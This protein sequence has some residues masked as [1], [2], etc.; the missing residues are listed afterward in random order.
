[1]KTKI[2]NQAEYKRK[3]RHLH[4]R[5][6]IVG[7]PDFPRVCIF[8]SS[9]H[10]YAQIIDD[11]KGH[12]LAA[13]S[14]QKI[15]KSDTEAAAAPPAESGEGETSDNTTAK[16]KKEKGKK[17]GG[18]KAKPE[19]AKIIQ[20]REVGRMIAEAA[21]EKGITKVKFDRGGYLYHGRVAALADAMRANGIE[22]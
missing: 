8:K 7:T 14:S 5:N 16:D 9:A 21:K 13:V 2:K 22:F 3:R 4:I 19:G 10:I 15:R 20:A 6:R 1:M 11:E 18:K 17:K 12:T